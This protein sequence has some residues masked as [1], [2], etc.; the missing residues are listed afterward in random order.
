LQGWN[1]AKIHQPQKKKKNKQW[2]GV[3]TQ[4]PKERKSR[5]LHLL[6]FAWFQRFLLLVRFANSGGVHVIGLVWALSK[7]LGVL[8]YGW[9]QVGC[10]VES[11]MNEM[12]QKVF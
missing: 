5:L 3:R 8:F 11:Q 12:N 6:R 7:Q 10:K 1:F 2:S 9:K 4:Q